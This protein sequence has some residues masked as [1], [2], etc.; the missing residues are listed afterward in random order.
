[1]R[2]CGFDLIR[3]PV[4]QFFF[5]PGSVLADVQ[6]VLRIR[7]K[8]GDKCATFVHTVFTAFAVMVRVLANLK[9]VNFLIVA[10]RDRVLFHMD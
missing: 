2:N 3:Q 8:A 1:M 9:V 5:K 6:K 7:L 10:D 4:Q